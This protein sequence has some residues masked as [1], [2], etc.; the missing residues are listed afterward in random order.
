MTE[1]PPA[2][3]LMKSIIGRIATGPELSKNISREE[4]RDGMA[5]ILAGE[6]DPIQIGIFFIALRMKRETDDEYLGILD[7]LAGASDLATAEVDD[8]AILGDPF[9]GYN[10]CLPVAP[11]L[12]P[13]LAACGLPTVSTGVDL[14]GPKYGVTHRRI[15]AAASIPVGRSAQEA[16]AELSRSG[17]A[18]CD[19][20][21]YAPSLHALLPVRRQ[22][23][24]RTPLTTTETLARPVAGRLRTHYLSGYVHAPYPRIY[25]LLARAAGFA[26]ASIVRGVEGGFIPSLRQSGRVVRYTDFGIEEAVD[27]NPAE[28]GIQQNV[29]APLLPG[30]GEAAE[31][32]VEKAAFDADTVARLAADAGVAALQGQAGASYD[33]LVIGAAIALW[34]C[35]TVDSLAAGA[36]AARQ[37]LDSGAAW[38]RFA[39]QR[40]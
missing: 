20:A 35:G 36:A 27:F 25:A 37:A 9:D 26:S 30:E 39:A 3:A 33:A 29:R 5:A 34:N 13:L 6:I 28:I 8:V 4:A 38:Q 16:A 31:A 12:P 32:E 21:S 11:F 17:W 19:Q 7:A 15:L 22:I 10:R 24:K 23:I 2:Q 40:A 18:Y 1:L 14:L